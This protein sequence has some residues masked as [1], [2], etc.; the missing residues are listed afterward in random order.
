MLS[1]KW[2]IEIP[3]RIDERE[4]CKMYCRICDDIAN[5]TNEPSL[6][7]VLRRSLNFRG[8]ISS[9]VMVNCNTHN[10]FGKVEF[11]NIHSSSG[12]RFSGMSVWVAHTLRRIL[13]Q[14]AFL[15][16]NTHE[17]LQQITKI[18]PKPTHHFIKMDVKSFYLSG[19]V[20]TLAELC[21]SHSEGGEN[22][23]WNVPSFSCSI[24]SMWIYL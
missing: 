1:K 7:G 23:F 9:R 10:P 19:D 22:M 17:L 4:L 20:M 18:K 12:N 15:L 21:C 6:A 13:Q 14:H 2:Y 24:I 5:V 3:H 8:G 16:K 11:R